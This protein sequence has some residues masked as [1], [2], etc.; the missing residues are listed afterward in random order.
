M[1]GAINVG[2]QPRRVA[3]NSNGKL[4]VVAN[5]DGYITFIK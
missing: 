5:Q 2:G 4:G 1:Q 3:F